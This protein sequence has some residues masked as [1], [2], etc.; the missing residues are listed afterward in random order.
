MKKDLGLKNEKNLLVK[1][2]KNYSRIEYQPEN[3]LAARFCELL[4][5]K[6]LT[7]KNIESLKAIGFTV[8]LKGG[9]L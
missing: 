7:Q 1:E 2:V 6:N 8:E 5:Q 4:G 3:P 9:S